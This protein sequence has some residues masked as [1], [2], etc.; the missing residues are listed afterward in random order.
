MTIFVV[1][2]DVDELSDSVLISVVQWVTTWLASILCGRAGWASEWPQRLGAL[3]TNPVG[4]MRGPLTAPTLYFIVYNRRH[5]FKTNY[6]LLG[7]TDPVSHQTK[8]IATMLAAVSTWTPFP[9][10]CSP[11]R[12]KPLDSEFQFDGSWCPTKN[13]AVRARS[14]LETS[15]RAICPSRRRTQNW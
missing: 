5:N 15:S 6:N 11:L 4:P 1:S 14:L 13:F 9:P 7:N 12:P 2:R 8:K 3:C 10:F